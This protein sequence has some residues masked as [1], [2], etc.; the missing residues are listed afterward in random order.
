MEQLA[1]RRAHNPKVAGSSPAPATKKLEVTVGLPAVTFFPFRAGPVESLAIQ[2][3]RWP[4][5]LSDPFDW[6][7]G[8]PAATQQNFPIL[9]RKRSPGSLKSIL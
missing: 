2:W 8:D 1:A 4:T 3:R 6:F 7:W 9:E 5:L